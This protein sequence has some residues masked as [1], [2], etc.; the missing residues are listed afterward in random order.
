MSLG[1]FFYWFFH[2]V[3]QLKLIVKSF[4]KLAEIANIS[5]GIGSLIF[6]NFFSLLDAIK[7]LETKV[8]IAFFM[9]KKRNNVKLIKLYINM[10]CTEQSFDLYFELKTGKI[11][12]ELRFQIT[13]GLLP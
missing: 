13:R 10:Y 1:T 7:L 12:T 5:L 8:W 4:Y 3:L 11:N 6:S 9:K 2:I